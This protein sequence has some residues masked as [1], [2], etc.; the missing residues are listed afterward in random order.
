MR[1]LLLLHQ[2]TLSM[3]L[4]L[5]HVVLSV[6]YLQSRKGTAHP[7]ANATLHFSDTKNLKAPKHWGKRNSPSKTFTAVYLAYPPSHLGA[8]IHVELF[9]DLLWL[10]LKR[11]Y[12]HLV[13]VALFCL[14]FCFPLSLQRG[15]FESWRPGFEYRRDAFKQREARRRPDHADAEQPGSSVP[16]WVWRLC[17]GW[18][19]TRGEYVEAR[20]GSVALRV[21][22]VAVVAVWMWLRLCWRRH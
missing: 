3:K 8:N 16:D 1:M 14:P 12:E 18:A 19:H 17:H 13:Q 9:N 15:H 5:W 11:F 22:N 6:F 20:L 2:P 21:N 7:E 10:Q 4:W